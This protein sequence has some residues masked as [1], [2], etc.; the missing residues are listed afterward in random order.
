[1]KLLLSICNAL[2]AIGN[3]LAE[4]RSRQIQNRRYL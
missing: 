2:L 1:M 3:F 4:Y